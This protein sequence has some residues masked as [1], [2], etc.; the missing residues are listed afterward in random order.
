MSIALILLL[1]K[2][3]CMEV[4]GSVE[5]LEGL[6]PQRVKFHSLDYQ[7]ILHWKHYSSSLR[8]P[9]YFVQYKIYGQKHWT[10]VAH[11]QGIREQLC[12]VTQQTAETRDWYYARVR[13]AMPGVLS[14]WA[15]SPRFNPHLETSVSP[16]GLR[17]NVTEQGIVVR[18][19][20]PTSPFR[21][22]NGS[23]ITMRKLHRLL[24]RVYLFRNNTVKVQR[25]LHSCVQQLL[26]AGLRRSTTY[27]LQA[28]VHLPELG[29][30]STKS[31]TACITTL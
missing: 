19:R 27:C 29:R 9:R 16:P 1:L 20:P 31:Q 18:L 17:L 10:D 30:S 4:A 3:T 5:L 22:R 12:D 14:S 25:E 6:A 21:R 13:A 11:C 26:I 8:T 15:L 24:Y 23:S 28:Q 2:F 7:N